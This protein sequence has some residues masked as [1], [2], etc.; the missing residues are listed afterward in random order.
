MEFYTVVIPK[1][2]KPYIKKTAEF[3]TDIKGL[4]V[5]C[6]VSHRNVRL[7]AVVK[8]TIKDILERK[9]CYAEIYEV[10]DFHRESFLGLDKH[11]AENILS[12]LIKRQYPLWNKK[13]L[14]S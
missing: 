9:S 1:N 14:N 11:V 7:R 12:E 5:P 2:K 8:G 3:P 4:E 10:S 13:P 6:S